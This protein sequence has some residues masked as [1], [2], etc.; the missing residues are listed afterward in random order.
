M[1]INIRVS[2]GTFEGLSHGFG[3]NH[4]AICCCGSSG[5]FRSFACTHGP[6]SASPSLHDIS[7]AFFNS[8]ILSHGML[9][10]RNMS[11]TNL[12]SPESMSS[13]VNIMVLIASNK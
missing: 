1:R 11:L 6:L 10:Q 7:F 4:E 12:N 9:Q 5:K 13:T 8:V 3:G 2:G